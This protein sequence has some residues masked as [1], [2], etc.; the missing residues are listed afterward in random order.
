[1]SDA[2]RRDLNHL[3]ALAG[4]CQSM[5]DWLRSTPQ[6]VINVTVPVTPPKKGSER[7]WPKLDAEALTRVCERPMCIAGAKA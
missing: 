3:K 6:P 4:S 5:G 2:A 1:M 7:S